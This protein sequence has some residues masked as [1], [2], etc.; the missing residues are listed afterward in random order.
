MSFVIGLVILVI[1]NFQYVDTCVKYFFIYV[2]SNFLNR[3]LLGFVMFFKII[4]IHIIIEL[5]LK[6][7]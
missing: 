3:L 4:F 5:S 2:F 1:K 6:S 7:S